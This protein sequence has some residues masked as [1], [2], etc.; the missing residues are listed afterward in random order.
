MLNTL[1]EKIQFPVDVLIS[2]Y[3][4]FFPRGRQG[5]TLSHASYKAALLCLPQ[6]YH[7]TGTM[8]HDQRQKQ[9]FLNGVNESVF[10][11]ASS[12]AVFLHMQTISF[13]EGS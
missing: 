1:M 9:L 6:F 11:A 10:L 2:N 8:L 3:I 7:V 5:K 12:R 13:T 4:I